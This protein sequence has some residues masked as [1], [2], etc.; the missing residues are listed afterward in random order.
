MPVPT[1]AELSAAVQ[2]A[3]LPTLLPALAHLSGDLGLLREDFR[4]N[5]RVTP[6]GFEAQGGLSAAAQDRAREACVKAL[7]EVFRRELTVPAGSG[8]D[9]RQMVEFMVGMVSDDYFQLLR[10]ELGV[11]DPAE[12][13]SAWTKDDIAPARDFRVAV[14]GAGM[15]GIAI[16][17]RLQQ[18]GIPF[19]VFERGADVGGV[20]L[21]NDYPGCR[22]DTSNF[23]YSYSFR[24]KEDWEEQYSSRDAVL[25]YL[26]GTA[27]W[28][29]MWRY[30]RF[31][32]Q[33]LSARFDTS[34]QRWDLRVRSEA[35]EQEWH[36]DA[37]ISAVGQLNT[38]KHPDIDDLEQFRGDSWHTAQWPAEADL[39]G[40]DV[41]VVGV[42]ASAFQAIQ[43]IATTARRVTVFQ[44]TPPWVLP[45]PGYL[46]PIPQG[47]AWLLR[48]VPGYAR[49][50]RVQQFW[51]SVDSRRRFAVVDP[52]WNKTGSVSADNEALRE[53]LIANLEKHLGVRPDLLAACTPDYPPYG[54][55]ALRD[56]GRWFETLKR[57]NVEVVTQ[58]ILKAVP[59]GLVDGTG[60]L[61]EVD[62][63]IFGTGF[64]ASDFLSTLEVIGADGQS[65]KDTWNGDARA[66]Y[67]V[68]IPGF[69]NL[70]CLYGPN[71]N[72][73]AN[74]SVVFF[75][76]CGANQI[77]SSLRRLLEDGY[78]SLSVRQDVHDRYNAVI[79]EANQNMAY[80]IA[81]VG[82]WYKNAYGRVS[83]NW[84]LNSIEYWRGTREVDPHD[85]DFK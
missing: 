33:V 13:V 84:P 4:P 9:L 14:I 10:H 79:D 51:S 17:A 6:T 76:E 32:H 25:E 31:G 80:G 18:V 39:E 30:T 59:A 37:V 53:V 47:Q 72:L 78:S 11:S 42:G 7:R 74:G 34:A 83:G 21:D 85:Y 38:P 44:R 48:S 36:F 70:F 41:A 24:Q 27:G 56:D 22:L 64:L 71:T 49:W 45:S 75:S 66:Y 50:H 35:G 12:E 43:E 55:R 19:V 65:L 62:T 60:R 82:S 67:G 73:L 16:T 28:L 81:G 29:D 58:P 69:P 40:R 15:S 63:L 61:H 23:S 68:T 57:E 5:Y 52:A 2:Q 77:V 8:A 26:Q 20:W 3:N 1:D 46:D 54:K